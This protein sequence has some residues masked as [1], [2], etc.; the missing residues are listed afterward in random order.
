MGGGYAMLQPKLPINLPSFLLPE[1][2]VH[3]SRGMEVQ[4]GLA[5]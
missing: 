3:D 5:D 2:F 4:T 1:S